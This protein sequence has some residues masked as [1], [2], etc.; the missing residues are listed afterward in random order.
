[1]KVRNKLCCGAFFLLVTAIGF[2]VPQRQDVIKQS[3]ISVKGRIIGYSMRSRFRSV[4]G[5][6]TGSPHDA[7]LFLIEQGDGEL[8]KGRYVKIQYRVTREH[9]DDLPA[10]FFEESLSRSFQLKKDSSCD[11]TTQSF[12][13]G[14]TVAGNESIAE[15]ARKYPNL[16][17]L[18]GAENVGLP[19]ERVLRCYVFDWQSISRAS[20]ES[21]P[22]IRIR[23]HP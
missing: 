12:L 15:A 17:R 8:K 4:Q 22:A 9:S 5:Q 23:F 21:P 13:V 11:E 7:F 20:I 6:V 2:G 14:E 19:S 1:M 18:R 16:V 10:T 3:E